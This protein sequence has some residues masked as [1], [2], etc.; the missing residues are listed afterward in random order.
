MRCDLSRLK[1]VIDGVHFAERVVLRA[2]GST[3]AA[4]SISGSEKE[5]PSRY[6]ALLAA[7]RSDRKMFA[8]EP[9][10]I[11]RAPGASIVTA[12][13]GFLRPAGRSGHP[14]ASRRWVITTR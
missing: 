1:L 5:R 10:K 2:A 4:T 7:P 14:F 3:V 8:Y 11:N 6:L 9:L 12:L 13:L